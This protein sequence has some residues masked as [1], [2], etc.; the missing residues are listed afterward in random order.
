MDGKISVDSTYGKGSTF[1]FELPQKIIDKSPSIP[2]IDKEL[3][4]GFLV[5]NEYVKKSGAY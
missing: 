2:C 1:F 3:S 5:G 4:V